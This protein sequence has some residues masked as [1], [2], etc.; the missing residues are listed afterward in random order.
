MS[1]QNTTLE[2]VIAFAVSIDRGDALA[3]ASALRSANPG[4]S[5]QE[6]AARVFRGLSW[7]GAGIGALT[8]LP[9]Q[10][11]TAIPAALADAAAVLRIEL[12][13]AAV[14]AALY[15]PTFLDDE[16]AH[17]ALIVPILGGN[18]MSQAL[19]GAGIA[20]ATQLSRAAIKKILTK[21]TLAAFRKAVVKIFG[22]KVT[23]R[24][25]VSKTVPVVGALVG[26]AWNLAEI[27]TVG[28]RVVEFFEA[29]ASPTEPTPA[30][31]L[32]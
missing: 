6:L 30:C 12:K 25:V 22:I 21:E 9:S 16:D 20:A 26:S 11:A 5:S 10:I 31:A 14:V 8:G 29:R 18:A 1:N 15:D 19:R 4:T 28:G 24:A 27:R 3:A 32:A 17:W 2:K 23:Q 13:G 7:K